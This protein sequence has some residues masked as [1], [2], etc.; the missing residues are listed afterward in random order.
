MAIAFRGV[1]AGSDPG[2]GNPTTAEPAGCQEDDVLLAVA[3]CED[4]ATATVTPATG[5]VQVTNLFDEG[6]GSGQQ[7]MSGVY[8]IRRG[9]VAV[10]T[11][12]T[13]SAGGAARMLSIV[14]YSG[15]KTTG[16]PWNGTPVLTLGSD[17]T[18]E[19]GS[20]TTSVDGC[21]MVGL[22]SVYTWASTV[23]GTGGWDERLDQAGAGPANIYDQ[24]QASAGGSPA[25][26]VTGDS[27]W[28]AH[29]LALE[30][31]DVPPP[32]TPQLR[33]VTRS[34]LRLN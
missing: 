2:A 26:T 9:A 27:N 23:T 21:M 16:D 3:N 22:S 4:N 17:N 31:A 1:T 5:W 6:T 13:I 19:F 12:W 24:L 29:L 7:L 32:P 8:W 14:A 18:A 30:P 33:G 11:N 28:V 34:G 25:L 15:V 20:L 10:A